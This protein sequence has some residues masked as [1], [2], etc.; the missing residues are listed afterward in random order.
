MHSCQYCLQMRV[1]PISRQCLNGTSF[2]P[3]AW[4]MDA[5]DFRCQDIWFRRE[6]GLPG[7][8]NQ[9]PGV[10]DVVVNTEAFLT[11]DSGRSTYRCLKPARTS[12]RGVI[13][14]NG[15][16]L[17]STIS[18][19]TDPHRRIE[20]ILQRHVDQ[21]TVEVETDNQ[22]DHLSAHQQSQLLIVHHALGQGRWQDTFQTA[23]HAEKRVEPR[24]RGQ[25][26]L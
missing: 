13:S 14:K 18:Y 4:C 12:H 26:R 7:G 8:K 23:Q 1:T 2:S 17:I 24:Q 3:S 5:S 11:L 19:S 15:D 20:V 22:V 21:N 25:I 10:R 9:D 6:A 16:C